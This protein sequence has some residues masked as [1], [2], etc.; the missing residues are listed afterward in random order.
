MPGLA[1]TPPLPLTAAER[2]IA[3]GASQA[4]VTFYA[5]AG[6]AIR[7]RIKTPQEV[8]VFWATAGALCM[9]NHANSLTAIAA[10]ETAAAGNG[11]RNAAN[12]KPAGAKAK[13]KSRGAGA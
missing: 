13:P 5:G 10:A 3:R 8:P 4:L 12:R 11:L 9:R 7:A 2:G 1:L 6:K